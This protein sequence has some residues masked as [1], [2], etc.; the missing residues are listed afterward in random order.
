MQQEPSLHHVCCSEE[1]AGWPGLDLECGAPAWPLLA[2][3]R[4][5]QSMLPRPVLLLHTASSM[6][7]VP[8]VVLLLLSLVSVCKLLM[9]LQPAGTAAVATVSGCRLPT[10]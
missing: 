9:L 2:V 8:A 5:A 3:Q 4:Q 1:A 6:Q 10:R 7:L